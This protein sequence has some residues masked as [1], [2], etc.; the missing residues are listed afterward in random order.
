MLTFFVDQHMEETVFILKGIF[1][2]LLHYDLR[3]VTVSDR[4]QET[5]SLSGK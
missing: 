5:S 4:G 3:D 1:H 2:A